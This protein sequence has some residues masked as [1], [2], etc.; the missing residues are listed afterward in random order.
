MQQ[1]RLVSASGRNRHKAEVVFS[2]YFCFSAQKAVRLALFGNFRKVH[3][4][5]NTRPGITSLACGAFL[6][7]GRHFVGRFAT[8]I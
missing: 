1:L 3:A 8:E 7:T 6:V 5:G 2:A 4:S